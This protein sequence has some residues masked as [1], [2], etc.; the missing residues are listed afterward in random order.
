MSDDDKKLNRREFLVRAG[1]L[2]AAATGVGMYAGCDKGGSGG[3]KSGGNKGGGGSKGGGKGGGGGELSCTDTSGLSE[4][5]IKTRE[6]L[7]YVDKSDKPDKDCANCQLYQPP[8]KEGECGGCQS[9]PG[10]IHPDGYCTAWVKK[11]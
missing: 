3:Q 4:S 7:K 2:G 1:M 8:E 9:V 10:P 5:E 6:Q 11:S